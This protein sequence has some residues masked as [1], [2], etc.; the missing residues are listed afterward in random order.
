MVPVL[1]HVAKQGLVIDLQDMF[2]RFTF[3]ITCKLVTRFDPGCLSVEFQDVPFSRALYVVEEAI[4]MRHC[5]P[6]SVCKLKKWLGIGH[7]KKLSQVWTIL[8]DVIGKYVSMK[9]EEMS[10]YGDDEQG[11]DLL[12]S[13][14]KGGES[15]GLE[16]DDKF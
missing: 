8:D 16:C 9:S 1:E 7:E 13:Y 15:T 14:I 4:F 3:D 12:T 2:Q 6:E 10:K 5:F 11:L